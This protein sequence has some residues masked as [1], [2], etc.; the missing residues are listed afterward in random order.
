MPKLKR[1]SAGEVVSILQGFGFTIVDQSGSHLKL[2]RFTA[3]GE[4]QTLIVPNHRQLDTGTCHAIFR[5]SS[6]Y[7]SVEELRPHFYS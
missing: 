6:R 7:I 5:Q 4:K 2:K 3:A 1:L